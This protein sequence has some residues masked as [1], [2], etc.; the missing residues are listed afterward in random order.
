MGAVVRR[1]IRKAIRERKEDTAQSRDRTCG[2]DDG[3]FSGVRAVVS[4]DV[5]F[6][7]GRIR[8]CLA[9]R[10]SWTKVGRRGLSLFAPARRPPAL[11]ASEVPLEKRPPDPLLSTKSRGP[12]QRAAASGSQR[13]PRARGRICLRVFGTC[14]R[15]TASFPV[16]LA[17]SARPAAGLLPTCRPSL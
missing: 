3:A 14:I 9:G 7:P 15:A 10:N 1:S 12:G 8:G 13:V 17:P 11:L 5:E 16:M 2:G 6:Q 4:T